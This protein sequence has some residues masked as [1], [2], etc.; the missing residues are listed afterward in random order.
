MVFQHDASTLPHSQ[1]LLRLSQSLALLDALLMP[2]WEY[3]YSSFNAHWNDEEMMASL[4]NGEGDG[5]F[6][7]FGQPGTA[8]KGFAHES[9]VWN[10][11]GGQ[12]NL[13]LSSLSEQ[14]PTAFEPFLREP[15]F[16]MEEMTFCLW[17]QPLDPGWT[18][19]QPP[20]PKEVAA[21]DG[22]AELLAFLDGN[23]HTYQRW[24][25]EYYGQLP[26]LDALQEIYAHKPLTD[27]ILMRLG[28]SRKL[29]ELAEELQEIGYPSPAGQSAG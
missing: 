22:S 10:S 14:I 5:Y 25:Q 7:W 29:N 20:V 13:I 3:R 6:I 11:L 19:W 18:K 17:K 24:A 4:R 8:L 9:A 12:R 27:D 26:A 1:P 21:D 28:S 16:L 15:A 23:P 2:E